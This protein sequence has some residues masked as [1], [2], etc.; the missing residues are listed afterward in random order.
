MNDAAA[1]VIVIMET[2]ECALEQT[3]WTTDGALLAKHVRF[4]SETAMTTAAAELRIY[5]SSNSAASVLLLDRAAAFCETSGHLG[6][7]GC[8]TVR[9][10]VSRFTH[11]LVFVLR[12]ILV[13]RV[14]ASMRR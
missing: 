9:V 13:A 2:M 8:G 6:A 5:G 11:V 3:G 14:R 10:R 1:A 4:R 12:P 7:C